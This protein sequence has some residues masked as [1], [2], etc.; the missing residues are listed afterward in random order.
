MPPFLSLK[1]EGLQLHYLANNHHFFVVISLI[2]S[3]KSGTY[4]PRESRERV[5]KG[6]ISLHISRVTYYIHTIVL[7]N[8][9]RQFLSEENGGFH[10]P[11]QLRWTAAGRTRSQVEIPVGFGTRDFYRGDYDYDDGDC[12]R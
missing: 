6:Y 2:G 10:T 4:H 7:R 3:T 11:S 12:G 9:W 8:S 1:K 5:V